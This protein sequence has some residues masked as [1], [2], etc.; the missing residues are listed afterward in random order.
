VGFLGLAEAAASFGGDPALQKWATELANTWAGRITTKPDERQR[1]MKKKLDWLAKGY[2]VVLAG[3]QKRKGLRKY[4]SQGI[5]RAWQ[6]SREQEMDFATLERSPY[7]P[8]TFAP[9]PGAVQ[10]VVTPLVGDSDK[11]P[12]APL[13]ASF[14]QKLLPLSPQVRADTY[15]NH[16]GGA[17]K[18]RGFSI[19]LWLDR[20][21]KDARG[22]WQPDH[23]LALLRAVHQAARA[24]GAEWRVLYNDYS[25][26]RVINQETRARRVAFVGN[27]RPNGSLNWH[28]PAP[29]LLHFHLDLAPSTSPPAQPN[30]PAPS[31]SGGVTPPS[32]PSAYRRFR[33]TTYHVVDQREAPPGAVRV[34]I[35]DNQGRKLAEGSPAF[36][37]Q[38]SLEGTGRLV[39]GRL[40][41]VTGKKVRVSHGDYAE[42]LAY[43]R[44]NLPG[45]PP[46]YSGLV[47][48]NDRVV[49][50][51]AFHE[52]PANKRGAG[53]GMQRGIPLIPFRTLAADIGR[54]K[55]SE[56]SWK[57]KGGLVPPG[58]RVYIK[59]YDGL[60][61]PD[62]TRHD[63]W[64]VVNDTG[65]G[66]FGAH[67]DVFAGTRALRKQVKL[68]PVGTVWFPGIEQRIPPSYDYGL[69]A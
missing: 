58:T 17:F 16:G 27:I 57:D 68:P 42:V 34:P 6:V 39:D 48:E 10:R 9:P 12:V 62:G 61:L 4:T 40:I 11:Y 20:S 46:G 45:R 44:R 35:Y 64:F 69:K 8:K 41:N 50:A 54:T 15:P 49:Q 43:H 67:I 22:F 32:D 23:A 30:A 2:E 19:D 51:L 28:G 38:V 13:V 21:P 14:M 3:A 59:E 53:Y 24:V 36:F 31:P 56:P 47:V 7:L 18:G 66:I 65:G 1:E 37:A 25:V 63:G 26:A 5:I 33:L 29:L 52:V 60:Q 55:K